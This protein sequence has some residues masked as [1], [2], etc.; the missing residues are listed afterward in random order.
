ME[1]LMNKPIKNIILGLAV[2]LFFADCQKVSALPNVGFEWF[3]LSTNQIWITDVTGLPPEASPG[4]LMPSHAED[5]LESSE[6]DFSETVKVK[7]QI[8]VQ[9]K[10]NGKQGWPGGLKN[11]E[12]IPSLG[13][14]HE[15]EFNRD[16]LGIPAKLKNG[17]V[18]FTYLGNDKWRVKFFPQ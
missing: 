14:T 18:R 7:N 4:R 13:T 8:K 16:E 9:W 3:N 1:N 5:Q 6:S 15:A 17:K 2:I 12:L 11:G 10:D